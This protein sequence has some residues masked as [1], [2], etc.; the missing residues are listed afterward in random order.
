M[1]SGLSVQQVGQLVGVVL[2]ADHLRGASPG[3]GPPF[4]GQ[5]LGRKEQA[6]FGQ[7]GAHLDSGAEE[8]AVSPR[9]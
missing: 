7:A 3:A 4:A 8:I 1:T 5:E 9:L 2:L 6:V